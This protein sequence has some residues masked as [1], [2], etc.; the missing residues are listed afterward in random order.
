MPTG[1]TH[2]P[3]ASYTNVI[4]P[5][6]KRK[7]V[8]VTACTLVYTSAHVDIRGLTQKS[9]SSPS[10]VLF[11]GIELGLSV[12]VTAAFTHRAILITLEFELLGFLRK[13]PC[14][15]PFFF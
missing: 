12:L 6:I 5:L 3:L 2:F 9:W 7:V 10:T 4:F 8:C 13:V 1:Y 15:L 14:S 11:L